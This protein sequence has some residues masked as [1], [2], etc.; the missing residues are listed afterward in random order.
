[1]IRF[2][3]VD[4]LLCARRALKVVVFCLPTFALA[5]DRLAMRSVLSLTGELAAVAS[6]VLSEHGVYLQLLVLTG[7]W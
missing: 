2:F 6:G 7:S 3:Y 1:M 5:H 4:V